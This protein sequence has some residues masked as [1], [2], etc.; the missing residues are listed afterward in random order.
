MDVFDVVGGVLD[1]FSDVFHF[2]RACLCLLAGFLLLGVTCHL[3]DSNDWEIVAGTVEMFGSLVA[4]IV[5][6][7]R[8]RG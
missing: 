4:G 6:E 1:V 7:V 8:A 2:W 5:W 3:V